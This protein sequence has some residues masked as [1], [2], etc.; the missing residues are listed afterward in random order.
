MK[1]IRDFILFLLWSFGSRL[2]RFLPAR[3]AY[4]FADLMI[5][6]AGPFLIPKKQYIQR[7]YEEFFPERRTTADGPRASDNALRLYVKSQLDVMRY[8]LLSSSN[9]D[10]YVTYQGL[11]HLDLALGTKR[12]V[13]LMF[14]HFGANQFIIPA[15]GHKGYRINQISTFPGTWEHLSG[16][17]TS[18]L[19]EKAYQYQRECESRLPVKFLDISKNIRPALRCLEKGEVLLV[20]FDGRGGTKWEKVNFL[21][22]E[23]NISCGPF[24]IAVKTGA[25]IL[26]AYILRERNHKHLLVIEEPLYSGG[27]ESPEELIKSFIEWFEGKI[28]KHPDHYLWLLQAALIRGEFD[29]VPLFDMD[30]KPS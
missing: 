4:S 7:V 10:K 29:D 15:L 20:A 11:E 2:I 9:I 27:E 24:Q 6:I 21:G 13:I 16:Q 8:P 28:R 23:A 30:S 3:L 1:T 26:P 18:W 22:H 17:K 25:S 5:S 19:R 14:G 12:G